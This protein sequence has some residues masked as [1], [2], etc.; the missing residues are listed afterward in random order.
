MSAMQTLLQ[1]V[2]EAFNNHR[3]IHLHDVMW[4]GKRRVWAPFQHRVYS[5]A[6]NYAFNTTYS[7]ATYTSFV[8]F[9][10]TS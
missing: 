10:T 6:T 5:T 7:T 3:A 9:N 1:D 8:L 2:N 4:K